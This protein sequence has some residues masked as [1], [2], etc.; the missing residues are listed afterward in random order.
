MGWDFDISYFRGVFAKFFMIL[1]G[2]FLAFGAAVEV[3]LAT[4]TT[5]LWIALSTKWIVAGNQVVADRHT[6]TIGS[7]YSCL[8][9][10]VLLLLYQVQVE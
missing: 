10:G 6:L 8:E 5:E 7:D 2:A 4:C 3:L 9:H 1:P